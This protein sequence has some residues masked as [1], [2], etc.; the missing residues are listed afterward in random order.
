MA[1]LSRAN[2]GLWKTRY[3]LGPLKKSGLCLL[4]WSHTPK[5]TPTAS[6]HFVEI[7][8]ICSS[9]SKSTPLHCALALWHSLLQLPFRLMS[10]QLLWPSLVPHN[11]WGPSPL[12][13][14][15]CASLDHLPYFENILK[16]DSK[17]DLILVFILSPC[18]DPNFQNY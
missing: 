14:I 13:W 9:L 2:P 8:T 7:E 5:P 1:F 10:T 6:L 16:Y 18:R 3:C 17:E 12:I 11:L 15:P 4:F